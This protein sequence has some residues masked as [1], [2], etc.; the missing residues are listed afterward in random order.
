MSIDNPGRFFNAED[1][2]DDNEDKLK[3]VNIYGQELFKKAIDILNV[4]TTITDI[5]PDEENDKISTAGMML[6][7]AYRIPAKIKGAMGMEVYSLMMENA[8]IIK[9]NA[10]E[11][12]TMLWTCEHIHGIER[13]YTDIL[14]RE[15]DAFKVLFI[16]WVKAFDKHNDLPDDWYLFND[17]STFPEDDEPFDPNE[18]LNDFDPDGDK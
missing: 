15:I 17:P 18:F 3:P 2:D 6:E 9:V 5:L 7:N 10:M 13:K 16:Q 12:K 14:R 11:L 4:T 8:V 1:F